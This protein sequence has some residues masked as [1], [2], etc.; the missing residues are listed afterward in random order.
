M[1]KTKFILLFLIIPFFFQFLFSCSSEDYNL[2][3][4]RGSKNI[5]TFERQL[6]NF[7]KISIKGDIY[8]NVKQGAR[9]EVFIHVNENLKNILQTNVRNNTLLISLKEGSYTNALF[10]LEIEL[11]FLQ[12]LHAKDDA[13]G[14]I[15]FDVNQLKLNLSDSSLF[16]LLGNSEALTIE[17]KDDSSID[18]FSFATKTLNVNISDDSDLN[19]T[20]H[21][22]LKGSVNDD[23]IL[24]YRGNP[25]IKITTSDESLV[26][27]AN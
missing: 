26:I 12:E 20:C 6:S 23:S 19:I 17:L 14:S 3:T 18:A 24:R 15:E 25:I 1:K 8:V 11:P 5:I 2:G 4:I 16:K 13:N 7:N 21:G 27:N 10:E 22:E 9:Q